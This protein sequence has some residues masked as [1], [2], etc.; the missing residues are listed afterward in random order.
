MRIKIKKLVRFGFRGINSAFNRKR[1]F[2]LFAK[3]TDD[4]V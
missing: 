4:E 1:K 2:F 3:R